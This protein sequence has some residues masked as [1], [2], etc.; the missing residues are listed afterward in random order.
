MEHQLTSPKTYFRKLAN[1]NSMVQTWSDIYHRKM[2][3]DYV[4]NRLQEGGKGLV[5]Y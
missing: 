4:R 5:I 1:G 3:V 2:S